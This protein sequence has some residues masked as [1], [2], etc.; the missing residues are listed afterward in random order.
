MARNWL[1]VG[2]VLPERAWV[3]IPRMTFGVGS[4][5]LVA[6]ITIEVQKGHASGRLEGDQDFSIFQVSSIFRDVISPFSN[7]I[8]VQNRGGYSIVVDVAMDLDEGRQHT[9]PIFEPIFDR[10]LNNGDDKFTFQPQRLMYLDSVEL[11]PK[12]LIESSVS[13][14]LHCLVQSS[15]YAK[16]TLMYCRMALESV[17]AFYDPTPKRGRSWSVTE[18][19]GEKAM[20]EPLKLNRKTLATFKSKAA[21]TRHG[22]YLKEI[23]WDE[24]RAAME[25]AWEVVNRH[26][27]IR[28]GGS[29]EGWVEL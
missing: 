5:A 18:A 24:R 21:A 28:R 12:I 11:V 1:I 26:I 10:V 19:L 6:S 2:R 4:G 22:V 3:D 15:R 16:Y 14:A 9:C 20:C 23:T 7:Y 29:P 8:G 27:F 25:V 13:G 17:R